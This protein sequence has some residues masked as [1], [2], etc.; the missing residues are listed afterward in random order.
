MN[1]TQ[2]R[3]ARL[4]LLKQDVS[5]P[6]PGLMIPHFHL[7][8][9]LAHILVRLPAEGDCEE[10]WLRAAR[11]LVDLL[12]PPNASIVKCGQT[13]ERK[14]P[15]RGARLAVMDVEPSA[16]LETPAEAIAAMLKIA[17]D[18]SPRQPN[19]F[20]QDHRNLLEILEQCGIPTGETPTALEGRHND[21]AKEAEALHDLMTA[22]VATGLCRETKLAAG[23][24]LVEPDLRGT[25]G[26]PWGWI[27][28]PKS[29]DFTCGT[30]VIEGLGGS[31]ARFPVLA[32]PQNC[33]LAVQR[34]GSIATSITNLAE[35][36]R[37]A[38]REIFGANTE[39]HECYEDDPE[40][41][42]L[43]WVPDPTRIS[44][45][46]DQ[47]AQWERPNPS[48]ETLTNLVAAVLARP[49]DTWGQAHQIPENH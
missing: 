15:W 9:K 29:G 38:L 33:A 14:D 34:W 6:A 11:A 23:I 42:A 48:N 39:I 43:P 25:N 44:G 32:V 27:P 31:T 19:I 28:G 24:T 3:D 20:D 41:M 21:M 17:R 45:A 46:Q 26:F 2:T 4:N 10:N 30:L 49:W 18:S 7:N 37:D 35:T 47:T 12:P 1:P 8:T 22:D 40:N 16:G 13:G 36:V 5:L